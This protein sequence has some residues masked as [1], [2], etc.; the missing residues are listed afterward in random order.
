[1][2]ACSGAQ[3]N[4]R[5]AELVVTYEGKEVHRASPIYTSLEDFSHIVE[6]KEDKYIIFGAEWCEKCKFLYKALRQSGHIDKVAILNLDEPW[7][8]ELYNATG[9]K[10]VPAM[11]VT[12]HLGKILAV[13]V[14][15]PRIVLYLVINLE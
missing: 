15:A 3:E 4:K 12:S 13:E 10:M 7:V 11:V 6:S 9:L 2:V 8:A 14:G 1:M 5:N